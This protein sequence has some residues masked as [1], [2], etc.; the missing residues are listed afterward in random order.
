MVRV[1]LSYSEENEKKKFIEDVLNLKDHK[2]V[3]ISKGKE[4]SLHRKIYI[5]LSQK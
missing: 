5:D 2:V 4:K 3:K 1:T